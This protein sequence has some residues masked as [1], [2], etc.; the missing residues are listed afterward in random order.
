MA[1]CDLIHLDQGKKFIVFTERFATAVYLEKM[2]T[3]E[4]PELRVASVVKEVGAMEYELKNFENEVYDMILDFAPEANSVEGKR[5]KT[6]DVLISTDAY[7]MGVNLQDASVVVNYDLAWTADTL[8]QRVGRILRFWT[9]PRKVYV[10][11]FVGD[12]KYD[13]NSQEASRKIEKRLQQLTLRTR[14]AEKFSELSIIPDADESQV[15]SL[16]SLSNLLIENLGEADISQI[17]E[18]SGGSPFLSHITELK[19]NLEYAEGIPDDITSAMIYKGN[20][21]QLYLLIKDGKTYHTTLYD[22]ENEELKSIDEDDLL[23]LIQCKKQTP[24]ANVLPDEIEE[25]AQKCKALLC[26][27][28]G[29]EPDEVERIC[30]L[31]LIPQSQADDFD[32][33]LRS[34]LPV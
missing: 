14:E 32:E 6:Y 3:Q 34:N 21:R 7:S 22:V 15:V 2:L 24:L 27:K 8:I 28:Q 4:M 29:L 19:Q 13:A 11:N 25:L 16:G 9:R 26:E 30:A 5:E 18:F 1:L 12:Y 20:S 31:Y 23:D 17:E 10:Y 33:M